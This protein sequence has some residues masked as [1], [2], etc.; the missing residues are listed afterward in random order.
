MFLLPPGL[1]RVHNIRQA[2]KSRETGFNEKF[3]E[4]FRAVI[5]Q[6]FYCSIF[7]DCDRAEPAVTA[8]LKL[9]SKFS[10]ENPGKRVG[11]SDINVFGSNSP[12]AASLHKEQV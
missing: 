5:L 10:G 8:P 9:L 11:I 2:L 12:I 4:S 1:M 3:Q 7:S 6:H